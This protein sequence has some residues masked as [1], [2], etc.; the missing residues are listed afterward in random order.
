MWMIFTISLA[1][2]D[3]EVIC[4]CSVPLVLIYWWWRKGLLAIGLPATHV[5]TFRT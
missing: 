3:V 2:E 1:I 5:L 4:I